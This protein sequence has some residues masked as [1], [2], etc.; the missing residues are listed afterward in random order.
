MATSVK[1]K[2]EAN[3]SS[4]QSRICRLA[5]ERLSISQCMP[6]PSALRNCRKVFG[7]GER[8]EEILGVRRHHVGL[9]GG[10][11]G[12]QV[13]WATVS[14]SSFHFQISARNDDR[15]GAPFVQ[16]PRRTI[17]QCRPRSPSITLITFFS[18]AGSM[19]GR[20]AIASAL[21]PI[22]ERPTVNFPPRSGWPGSAMIAANR[23]SKAATR[24]AM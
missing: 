20:L 7:H 2:R 11:Q 22:I 15:S 1:V 6:A 5:I 3:V 21:K 19:A 10:D 14:G 4:S 12:G 24:G 8:V 17:F 9:G 16:K 18:S 23:C 13:I